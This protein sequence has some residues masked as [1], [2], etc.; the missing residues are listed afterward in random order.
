[1]DRQGGFEGEEAGIPGGETNADMHAHSLA[2]LGQLA[3]VCALLHSP[4][5]V[6]TDLCHYP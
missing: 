6:S 3:S 1:M 4:Q 5:S 2:Q